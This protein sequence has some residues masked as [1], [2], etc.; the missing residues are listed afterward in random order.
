MNTNSSSETTSYEYLIFGGPNRDTLF[1][2]CKY[3]YDKDA[4]IPIFFAVA[5]SYTAPLNGP[6]CAYTA[7]EMDMTSI[8]GISHEDGSGVKLI[9]DGYCIAKFSNSLNGRTT[10]SFR[11]ERF[12]TQKRTRVRSR[13]SCN[14]PKPRRKSG[15]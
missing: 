2:A 15:F 12:I 11:S 10:C 9:V 6:I 14:T 13:F 7:L 1:D 3:A 8:C 4:V 5:E